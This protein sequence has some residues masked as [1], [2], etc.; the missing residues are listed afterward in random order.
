MLQKE[1]RNQ[2]VFCTIDRS[3]KKIEVEGLAENCQRIEDFIRDFFLKTN[4]KDA[5]ISQQKPQWFYYD[6]SSNRQM[7]F[8]DFI[9][10]QLEHAY[11][12]DPKAKVCFC[13]FFFEN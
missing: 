8:N 2:N 10:G 13:F 12:K 5:E 3:N 7:L 9:R 6:H 4:R 11:Q 1:C